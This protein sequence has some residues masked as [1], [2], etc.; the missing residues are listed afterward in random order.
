MHWAISGADDEY[1]GTISLK[2]IDRENENAEYAIVLR[3]EAQN[4]GYGTEATK[5]ILKIAFDDFNLNRVYLTVIENNTS[6]IKLYEKSGFV[7]E[8]TLREHLRKNG[9][10][11]GWKLYGILRSDY[12]RINKGEIN[13]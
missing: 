10:Y 11:I 9:K 2:K 3:K 1:L 12:I 8:G 7:Y 4:K 13:E 5:S 6:A